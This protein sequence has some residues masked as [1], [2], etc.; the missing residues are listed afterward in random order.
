MNPTK[1]EH[2]SGE[3]EERQEGESFSCLLFRAPFYVQGTNCYL[4]PFYHAITLNASC[5]PRLIASA[6]ER[7]EL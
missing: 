2:F 7:F 3:K 4:V 5:K 6:E 1:M